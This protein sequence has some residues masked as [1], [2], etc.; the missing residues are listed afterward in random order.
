[1]KEKPQNMKYVTGATQSEV[2]PSLSLVVHW[3]FEPLQFAD[4]Q[5]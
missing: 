4:N 2:S 3:Q 1:M 5:K